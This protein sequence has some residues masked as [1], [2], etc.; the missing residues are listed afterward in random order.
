V[1]LCSIINTASI[2]N[3]WT[4][5]CGNQHTACLYGIYSTTSG[6]DSMHSCT[7]CYNMITTTFNFIGSRLSLCVYALCCCVVWCLLLFLLQC[8]VCVLTSSSAV[9]CTRSA[10]SSSS[11][12]KSNNLVCDSP[13]YAILSIAPIEPI[14]TV[15]PT[16]IDQLQRI[17][18]IS[19]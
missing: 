18:H 11:T 17:S 3:N 19:N 15:L 2:A 16:C 8:C 6:P 10:S 12:T 1:L 7:Q 5:S 13:S 4:H 9:V 14:V